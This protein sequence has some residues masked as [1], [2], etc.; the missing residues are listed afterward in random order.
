MIKKE[1][2]FILLFTLLS[3][4]M[5]LAQE[6]YIGVRGGMGGGSMT[7]I[8]HIEKATNIKFPEFGVTYKRISE[9]KWLGG[10]QIEASYVKSGFTFLPRPKSDSSYN[11]NVNL[12]E[13]P[14][15]WHPHYAF[16]KKENFK[17]FLNAGPYISYLLD[18]D[19][20]YVDNIDKT[21]DYNRSGDYVYN[22][23]LDV[24]L[25]YGVMGGAGIE[26]MI[27]PKI[28]AQLEFR[29]KFAFSDI[30]KNKSKVDPALSPPTAAEVEQMFGREEYVQS[31]MSQMAISFALF[32]RFGNFGNVDKK[33]KVKK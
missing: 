11:R 7:V 6:H 19:Y 10:I 16:G 15:M 13:M 1:I 28:E 27:T 4:T 29:Y 22:R 33:I 21:S 12:I 5:L 8:P 25:G 18:S 17:V 20:E 23:Y 26:V 32:Y 9:E 31:Q 2:L 24:R 30:W 14:F 3:Q